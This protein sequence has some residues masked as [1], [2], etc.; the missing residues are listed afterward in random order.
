MKRLY[1]IQVNGFNFGQMIKDTIEKEPDEV[2]L[3]GE[4]EW[5]IKIPKD[6]VQS[7]KNL[8]VKLRVLHGSFPS[9]YYEDL[10]SE[11]GL[12][13][14]NVEFW[15]TSWLNWT[16]I[17][18]EYKDIA[19]QQFKYP[20]ISMNNR[21][22]L[23]RCMFIDELTKLNMLDKGAVSWIKHLNE[24]KN[25]KFKYFDNQVRT[26]NDDFKTK[27]DSFLIPEEFHQSFFHVVTEATN[28]VVIISEKTVIPLLF[29]KPFISLSGQYFHKEMV[30]L[31]FKLYD[32]IIDYS[33]DMEPDLQKRTV[34]FAANVPNIVNCDIEKTYELLKPKLEYNY[35][36]AIDIMNDKTRLPKIM[37]ER[38]REFTP[39]LKH[40]R[41][42]L[43]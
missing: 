6:F 26:F 4:T 22:H 33:F 36:H 17:Q 35:Q 39:D 21:S 42:M 37:L 25:Y 41:S 27:L 40:D 7:M 34:K 31:G 2:I 11:L 12:D 14:N 8:G 18:L 5:E 19:R 13:Y 23:H 16:E 3:M 30:E 28:H 10:Y 9:K 32:E 38:C 29:K 43:F 15:K 1:Y 20:F 24:N